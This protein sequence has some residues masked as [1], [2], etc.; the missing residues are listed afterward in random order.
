[1]SDG[2]HFST[3][4]AYTK[5]PKVSKRTTFQDELQ[6]AIS[7]RAG[8]H[9]TSTEETQYYSDDFDDVDEDDILKEF[10]SSK[11]NK[12]HKSNMGKKKHKANDFRF[13]D[14]DADENNEKPKKVSF[15][16]T[17][18]K[19]TS[20][21]IDD[22]DL[23]TSNGVTE[24]H[25]KQNSQRK[26]TPSLQSETSHQISRIGKHW[27]STLSLHSEKS[28]QRLKRDTEEDEER[29]TP[30]PRERSQRCTSSAGS[31]REDVPK[32][33]P[34]ERNLRSRNAEE[35]GMGQDETSLSRPPT[36]S[37]SIPLSPTGRSSRTSLSERK[38]NSR[39]P[40]P[41][42]SQPESSHEPSVSSRFSRY[43]SSSVDGRLSDSFLKSREGSF[44]KEGGNTEDENDKAGKMESEEKSCALMEL[45]MAEAEGTGKQSLSVDTQVHNSHS[46]SQP[47]PRQAKE[48]Q[49]VAHAMKQI[50]Q[51]NT[52]RAQEEVGDEQDNGT[53]NSSLVNEP[54]STGR[55][56][57][58]QTQS[59][60]KGRS[61]RPYTAESRYLGTLKVLDQKN[62]QEKTNLEAAD[63]IRAVIYQEWLKKKKHSS[64]EQLKTKKLEEQLKEEKI[65]KDELNKKQEAKES[66]EAW[67][68]QKTKVIKATVKE[69][70]EENKK[71][72]K[73]E[74][75]KEEQKQLAK[76]A[77]FEK[78]KEEKDDIL[79]NKYKKEKQAERNLKQKQEE[80]ISEKK[81][82]SISAFNKWNE[83]KEDTIH[84][85]IKTERQQKKVMRDM[86]K[87]QKKEKDRMALDTYE[88]WLVRKE[89][90]EKR[91][92]KQRK[93]RAILQD[94]PPPPWSP[95]NK[96]VPF[97]K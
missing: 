11:K 95:P 83:T 38:A 5:S 37:V 22:S 82:E 61:P 19:S 86:V 36:S 2:D 51:D 1:M 35:D 66:F 81:R 16:K 21:Y 58:S 65:K 32:P 97:G 44:T 96:T 6:A 84:E 54:L 28:Q 70:M 34:R 39:S 45:M 9:N 59:F 60:R 41:Q 63:T 64:H 27:D 89:R 3:T 55:P 69:K 77:V 24:K 80:E 76:K 7:A 75:E 10:F 18:R 78:W 25:G 47:I 92:Q 50:L 73:E 26:S 4:L 72:Q 12:S 87:L 23:D 53:S 48:Q 40:S 17:R 71:K 91:E 14:D 30:H 8:K 85:K 93:L 52:L 88:A 46:A 13:S 31:P 67:K 79:K 29:P 68:Q 62:P 94:E 43:P 57:S 20:I 33:R 15:L 49:I 74:E 90:Q 56:L 42:S